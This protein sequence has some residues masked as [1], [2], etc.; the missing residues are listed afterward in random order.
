M[1]MLVAYVIGQAIAAKYIENDDSE[2]NTFHTAI[3]LLFFPGLV[4]SNLF[5]DSDEEDDL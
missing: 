2:V 3:M 4:L 5:S 1:I